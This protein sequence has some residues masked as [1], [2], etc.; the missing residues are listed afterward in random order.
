MAYF[1]ELF[2]VAGNRNRMPLAGD[3]TAG[4]GLFLQ[5]TLSVSHFRFSPQVLR[6]QVKALAGVSPAP[7]EP[8]AHSCGGRKV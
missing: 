5:G 2:Q 6:A 3:E 1:N 4:S 7:S 8:Q